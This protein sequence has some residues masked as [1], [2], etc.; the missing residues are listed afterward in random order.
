MGDF[1]GIELPLITAAELVL[2][3]G[4]KLPINQRCEFRLGVLVAVA[5]PTQ[6]D[7]DVFRQNGFGIWGL[8]CSLP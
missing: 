5:K 6:Q 4:P 8:G 1:G 7:G 2:S 3:D